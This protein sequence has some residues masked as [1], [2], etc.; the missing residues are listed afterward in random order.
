LIYRDSLL[1]LP[2]KTGKNIV[3]TLDSAIQNIAQKSLLKGLEKARAKGGFAIVSD[4]HTGRILAIANAS[5]ESLDSLT[6]FKPET[7]RNRALTDLFEPG[8][9]IKPL[10]I[11][12]A[13]EEGL[14]TLDEVHNTYNGS[15]RE[16]G[17][18]HTI[19]DT[20]GSPMMTTEEILI[21]SSNIGTFRIAKRLGPERLARALLDFGLTQKEQL[22]GFPGQMLGRLSDWRNWHPM[23][24]ANVAFG[25]G[26]SA[27]GLE[28]IQAFGAIANGGNL[29]RPYLIDHIESAEGG[30]LENH[31]S[32]LIR[33]VLKPETSRLLRQVLQKAVEEG[34][35]KNASL[36]QFTSAGK[37]G[38]SQKVD[39]QTRAYSD[40]LRIA[41]FIGFAPCTD[42]HLV[43]YVVIDEPG[44]KPYYGGTWAAPVFKEIAD[45]SLRYLNV[46]P[47]KSEIKDT[48]A[49]GTQDHLKRSTD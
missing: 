48:L 20:H 39:P 8:S 15:Y 12:R 38:T 26:I 21:E 34:T 4:P 5:S 13:I 42:P 10:V 24:F 40:H 43:I 44:N 31:A 23:R 46:A 7:L 1:A 2:E 41:S 11:G 28:I 19:H 35:G 17:W 6:R 36:S 9:V 22:I 45:E 47:N 37:T 18:K 30:M 3:L 29:M 49:K 14:T 16:D 25:Q 27:T 32:E 33:R